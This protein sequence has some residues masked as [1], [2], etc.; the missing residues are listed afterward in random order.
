MP[1]QAPNGRN[2]NLRV[3]FP[4]NSYIY[5]RNICSEEAELTNTLRVELLDRV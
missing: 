5:S 2:R 4:I 3:T 1:Q